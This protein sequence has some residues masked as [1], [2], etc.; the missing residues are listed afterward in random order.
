MLEDDRTVRPLT[1]LGRDVLP[2]AR[3]QLRSDTER[4]CATAP[5]SQWTTSTVDCSPGA[6]FAEGPVSGSLAEEH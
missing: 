6:T 3:T 4:L 2:R 1:Q 5:M